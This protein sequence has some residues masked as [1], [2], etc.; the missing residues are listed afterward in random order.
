[1]PAKLTLVEKKYSALRGWNQDNQGQSLIAFKKSCARLKFLG[2]NYNM[3]W[4]AGYAGN[5]FKV[6]DKANTTSPKN[7]RKFFEQNFT[8]YLVG[9]NG[10]PQ[11]VFTGY[12]E[13]E[14]NGS[15]VS[16]GK[17]IHPVYK[18]PKNFK[19]PYLSRKKIIDGGLEG[20]NLEIA[21][22]DDAVALFF[23]HI[24]GSGRIKLDDGSVIKVGYHNQNGYAY[25]S[26]GRLLVETGV[27]ELEEVTAQKV[28][29]YLYANEERAYALMNENESYIF[30]RKLKATKNPIGAQ[31]VELTPGY[32]L[33]VDKRF[34]QYSTPIWLETTIPLDEDK[35]HAQNFHRL[36]IAQDTGG[37]IKGIV[38]GD[39]FLGFGKKAGHTAGLMRQDG[40]YYML[41]PNN[42]RPLVGE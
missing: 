2:K 36:M 1:M 40:L 38:R 21:Y 42:I 17:Y 31:S 20:K 6:C 24:Q 11:G 34:I 7:A 30:F 10:N 14:L 5:W 33:A 28:K 41:L 19:K 22:V 16:Y 26:I 23:L 12:Y 18:T 35:T 37:A 32:S 4:P 3:G 27:F 13:P 9:D 39:V 25:T 8:P 29:N 15:R